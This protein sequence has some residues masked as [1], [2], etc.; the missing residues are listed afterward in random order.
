MS[1]RLNPYFQVG[2][3][4]MDRPCLVIGGGEEAQDKAGR[5]LEAGACLTLVS[6]ELTPTL[7]QWARQG[8]FTHRRRCFEP[9]D[10]EGAFL[11]LNTVG[12][13]PALTRQ[14]YE[15]ACQK[16]LLVSSYDQPAFSNLG[17]AALVH[18]GHL[19]LSI[20]TSNASPALS[21]RLRQDLESLF[22]EEFIQYL[23]HLAQ[24]RQRVRQ[25]VPEAARRIALLRSLV[26]EFRLEGRLHYPPNWRSRVETLLTCDLQQCGTPGRCQGCPLLG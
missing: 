5:L 16:R 15:L 26:A 10:L 22:D 1:G 7:E 11:V 23:E 20:S 21:R 19:R 6:P 9:T 2:L 17:M 13:D 4:V 8:R 25:R 18:P 14:V 12:S 24:A 3:D